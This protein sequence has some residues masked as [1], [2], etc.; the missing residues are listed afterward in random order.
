M[1]KRQ[2]FLL[3]PVLVLSACGGGDDKRPAPDESAAAPSIGINMK[4]PVE[5]PLCYFVADTGS[6]IP[7]TGPDA[8]YVFVTEMS[9]S[10]YRGHAALDGVVTALEEVEAGFGAGMETRRYVNDAS[11]VE[12]EVILLDEVETEASL[13]YKGSVRVI[14]PVEG[15]AVKFYGECRYGEDAE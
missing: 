10:G 3:L 6:P 8:R 1:Y 13:R 15:E 11:G 12:L 5:D 7:V 4:S 2:V 14:Y 9:G